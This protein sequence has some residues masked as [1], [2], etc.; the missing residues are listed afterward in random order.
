M[1]TTGPNCC[2]PDEAATYRK[3]LHEVGPEL[4]ILETVTSGSITVKKLC[5][6]FGINITP[7]L[8]APDEQLY[9]LLGKLISE[10]L[11]KRQ[12]LLQ[13]NTIDDAAALLHE[14]QNVVVITGAG[15]STSLGIPDFRSKK[16]G[17]YSKLLEMGYSD[18]EEVFDIH[19]FDE[20]PR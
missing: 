7:F 11:N 5:T 12:K 4:F 16:T 8:D 1:P 10:E 13:Y 2:G 14:S 15:I 9:S 19:N 6:A 17:F 20:D 18:P 3:R